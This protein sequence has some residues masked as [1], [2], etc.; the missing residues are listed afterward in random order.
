MKCRNDHLIWIDFV[1]SI[2]VCGFPLC[3][4]RAADGRTFYVSSS[5]GHVKAAGTSEVTAWKGLDQVNAADLRPGDTVLF[6]RGDTW[7][8]PLRPKNGSPGKPVTYGAYGKGER[9]LLL[10]S[11]SRDRPDD[12]HDEGGTSGPLRKPSAPS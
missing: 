3:S 9:P 11:V 5:T 1:L 8:G 6:R 2:I 10:G 7:R 4:L 12:W